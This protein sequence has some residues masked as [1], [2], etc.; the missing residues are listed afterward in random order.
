MELLNT[1]DYENRMFKWRNCRQVYNSRYDVINN[2]SSDC[3]KRIEQI[4][5]EYHA[6]GNPD[7]LIRVL[8]NNNYSCESF[9]GENQ[10]VSGFIIANKK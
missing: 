9:D 10:Y 6:S 2:L 7:D 8:S 1:K 3:F 4:F 5:I